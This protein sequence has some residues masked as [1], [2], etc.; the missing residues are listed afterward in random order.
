MGKRNNH[1]TITI[2]RVDWE[3]EAIEERNVCMIANEFSVAVYV[4]EYL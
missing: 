2:D 3:F 1:K 4:C